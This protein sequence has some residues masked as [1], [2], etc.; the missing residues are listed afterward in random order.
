[1]E[2]LK[3]LNNAINFIKESIDKKTN[4]SRAFYSRF[5]YPLNGW[6]KPYPE[7]TGYII[8]TFDDLIYENN[9]LHLEDS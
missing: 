9:Y 5:L 1:M 7:T 3:S 6:S 8:K 2:R 4:G